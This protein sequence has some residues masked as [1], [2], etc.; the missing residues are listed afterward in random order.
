MTMLRCR[1]TVR[2]VSDGGAVWL[3]TSRRMGPGGATKKLSNVV[4]HFEDGT[5]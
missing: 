4:L 3:R 1:G 5:H 2:G